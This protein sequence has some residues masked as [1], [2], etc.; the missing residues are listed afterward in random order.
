[1]SV[2]ARRASADYSPN[3]H[4]FAMAEWHAAPN[5]HVTGRS[6]IREQA[7]N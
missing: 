1:L 6:L 7:A 2:P 5:V 4:V 3:D